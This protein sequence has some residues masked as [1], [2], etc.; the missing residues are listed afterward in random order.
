MYFLMMG[1]E[2]EKRNWG[3]GCGEGCK[4]EEEGK[5]KDGGEIGGTKKLK[6]PEEGSLWPCIQL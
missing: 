4:E 1:I 5:S 6:Q 2:K 3:R